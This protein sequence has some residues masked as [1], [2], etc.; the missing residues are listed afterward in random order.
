MK[1]VL[2][3][4]CGRNIIIFLPFSSSNFLNCSILME[5]NK[6]KFESKLD[7]GIANIESYV[8]F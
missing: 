4:K 5:R 6:E 2:D 1:L 8:R 3:E 7:E